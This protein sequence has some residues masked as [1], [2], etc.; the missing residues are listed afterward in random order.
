MQEN[1]ESCL[2]FSNQTSLP[3]Q[4]KNVGP[5]HIMRSEGIWKILNLDSESM[6]SERC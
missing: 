5:D 6:L 4:R 3:N 2:S 1:E